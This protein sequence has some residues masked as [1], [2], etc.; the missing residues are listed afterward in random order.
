ML[1]EAG[2]DPWR[3]ANFSV[4]SLRMCVPSST[5]RCQHVRA[6]QSVIPR[7]RQ[8]CCSLRASEMI[9]VVCGKITP[10]GVSVSRNLCL[11]A[12]ALQVAL[13]SRVI[14]CSHSRRFVG[15]LGLWTRCSFDT[16]FC[17]PGTPPLQEHAP[18]LQLF[19]EDCPLQHPVA[20]AVRRSQP[21]ILEMLFAAWHRLA[22]EVY[23]DR[24]SSDRWPAG[25][26]GS[27]LLC[28]VR[29]DAAAPEIVRTL[30]RASACIQDEVRTP[31]WNG[32]AACGN[33]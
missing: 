12:A 26:N 4:G 1:L 20:L 8:F 33:G 28:M 14:S 31:V 3:K 21:R 19:L 29:N 9:V 18:L 7:Q 2:A 32:S 15:S 30:L 6:N 22:T 27:E 10:V 16:S 11:L 5:S 23:P 25:G 17:W 13:W 24:K